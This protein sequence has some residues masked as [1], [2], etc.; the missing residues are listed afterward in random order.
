MEPFIGDLSLFTVHA[1]GVILVAVLLRPLAKLVR[2]SYLHYWSV[3]WVFL[4]LSLV[5]LSVGT[6]VPGWRIA[7]WFGSF[8]CEYLFATLI[9]A[10][11][12]E[13]T[14]P[15]RGRRRYV[16]VG[17]PLLMTMAI[18]IAEVSHFRQLFSLHA[19]F[20]GGL[21]FLCLL[22]FRRYRP[23]HP[24]TGQRL[25]QLALFGLIVLSGHYTVI[26]LAVGYVEPGFLPDY[27]HFWSLY[28]LFFEAALAVGMVV[29]ATEQ[30]REDLEEKNRQLAL[31]TENL[32][33]VART[34]PLTGLLNRRALDDTIAEYTGR[35]VAGA[36]GVID[37]NEFKQLNDSRGHA[38][39]DRA[40][41]RV[42]R[43]L[44]SHFRV[45]DPIFRTG[46]DEFLILFLNGTADELATRLDRIDTALHGQWRQ[47][48][49]PPIT[50]SIAWGVAT[51]KTAE[52]LRIAIDQA[53]ML[54][55]EQ[56][57]ARK[58]SDTPLETPSVTG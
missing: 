24:S 53:D 18:G 43:T 49:D 16:I 25:I 55:Y 8:F 56:K 32:S 19:A 48:D 28:N 10:G 47:E 46:G 3:S 36:V 12:D 15:Q 35:Y 5:S 17:V 41:Q 26:T 37:L 51:F 6:F 57:N 29:L 42:T 44:R 30:I 31:A 13:L 11:C 50:L 4:A 52:E 34:D 33:H 23:D 38:A 45:S 7:G 40:L 21:S 27:L 39:G 22:R 14:S 58:N 2:S 1:A 20:M 54:M 9:W